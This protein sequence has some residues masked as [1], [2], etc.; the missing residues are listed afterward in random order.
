MDPTRVTA[1]VPTPFHPLQIY[2]TPLGGIHL[3]LS[4]SGAYDSLR[5]RTK[6]SQA[7]RGGQHDKPPGLFCDRSAIVSSMRTHPIRTL[8][9]ISVLLCVGFAGCHKAH[10]SVTLSWKE[11]RALPGITIAGYNVYRSTTS[12]G[13]FVKLASKISEPHYED[14]L[15]VNGRT[16]FYV[17]TALDQA[18]RESRFSNETWVRIP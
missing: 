9:A 13:P 2:P 5:I 16:Y 18:G 11:P 7:S 6:K 8:L 14:D 15:A 12:G 17:V 3:S 4:H 1:T 10:H